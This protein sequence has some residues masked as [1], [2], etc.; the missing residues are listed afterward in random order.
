[1]S[2]IQYLHVYLA[3]SGQWAGK[4]LE[5]VAGIGGCT[6]PVDVLSAAAEQFPGIK[7]LPSGSS[8]GIQQAEATVTIEIP[9]TLED[10]ARS[11]CTTPQALLESF[12]RDLCDLPGSNG[13]DER[14]AADAWFDRVV[15]PIL[16]TD[17]ESEDGA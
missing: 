15:W 10:L 7:D 14:R 1:M 3:P 12:I 2:A 17:E 8:D 6:Y 16:D 9:K 11:V 4:V 5:E 13:S